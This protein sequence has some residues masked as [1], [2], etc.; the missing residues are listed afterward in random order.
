MPNFLATYLSSIPIGQRAALTAL[1]EQQ[2]A[3]GLIGTRE[4]YDIELSKLLKETTK[5]K[6]DVPTEGVIS[7]SMLN[8][9]F[10]KVFISLHGLFKQLNN[11][12]T[13]VVRHRSVSDSDIAAMRAATNK[14]L[15]DISIHQFLR[16]AHDG[17]SEAKFSNF[18][19]CRNASTSSQAADI[20]DLTKNVRLRIGR[21]RRLQ[22]MG[23]SVPTKASIEPLGAGDVEAISKS[24]A[25]KNMLDGSTK[26]FWAHMVLSDDPIL[27][28]IG[29]VEQNGASVRVTLEFPHVEPMSHLHF[30][31]F[32]TRP[33]ALSDLEYWSGE[34][35][36]AM[37][38]VTYPTASLDWQQ[39]EFYRV[40][41][42]KLR[43]VLRQENYQQNTYLI[44][45]NYFSNALLWEMALDDTL[46]SGL[47]EEDL[48]GAQRL[49]VDTNPRFRA[50]ASA[51]K[52]FGDRF[53]ES[54][55]TL[56]T[57]ATEELSRTI[58]AAA[59]VLAQANEDNAGT[60]NRLTGG[61]TDA[62]K[63]S[64]MIEITKFEYLLGIYSI[65][66]EFRDYY[67]IGIFESPK[68]SNNGCLY[69]IA[70]DTSEQHVLDPTNSFPLT[71]IEYEIELSPDRRRP[72]LPLGTT[73]VNQELLHINPSLLTDRTRFTPHGAPAPQLRC[74]GV[75]TTNFTLVGS[76]LTITAGFNRNKV[77][78]L[79]YDVAANQDQL[80]L[81]ATY[82]S[83]PLSSP[84]TFNET[85]DTGKVKLSYFPYVSRE[86]INNEHDWH[87]VDP[88]N[89]RWMY[90]AAAGITVIDGIT[91]GPAGEMFYEPIRVVV[92]GIAA[93]NITDYISGRNPAFVDS[94][95]Q[96]L[97]YRYIHVG[98]KLY[99]SRPIKGATIDVYYRW[100]AQYVKLVATLRG[101]QAVA[102]PYTPLLNN[103]RIRMRTAQL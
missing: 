11:A 32:S 23:G 84:E 96:E 29:G 66:V 37:A 71:S 13:T 73:R 75:T 41:T 70:I 12:D 77:Y 38:G 39:L 20:D 88:D 69:E 58:D 78:T 26:T 94:P 98:R 81:D 53:G 47:N 8:D 102:N 87:L 52:L 50:L 18:W 65:A 9:N 56:D 14:L 36:V 2:K 76:V 19:N 95:D 103:Y 49:A 25:P 101:H 63:P 6:F 67:P 55:I 72:I 89:A 59:R 82:N 92:D 16:Y 1:L 74:D 30:L 80:D 22:Q 5:L 7:S 68:Y 43:F 31:P 42:N 51:I 48:T 100:M 99:F 44:P 61:E 79:D 17:W 10:K 4:Q 33:F 91:Y 83:I 40:N 34:V 24:F 15:E 93:V 35:W 62:P 54:G 90:R 86:I 57:N 27:S 64:D 46:L 21:C 28:N 60:M 85:D 3:A 97:V 45:R